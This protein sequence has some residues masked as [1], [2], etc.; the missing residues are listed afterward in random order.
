MGTPRVDRR[1]GSATSHRPLRPG[2]R[3]TIVDLSLLRLP[4]EDGRASHRSLAAAL[5]VSTPTVRER[6]ARLERSGVIDLV[7]ANDYTAE[8]LGHLRDGSQHD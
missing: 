8:L 2:L 3:R 4:A 6:T 1:P 7:T 5:S